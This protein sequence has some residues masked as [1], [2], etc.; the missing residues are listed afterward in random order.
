MTN[1]AG[2]YSVYGLDDTKDDYIIIA[3][4]RGYERQAITGQNPAT[5]GTTANFDLVPPMV[6]YT[7]SGTVKTDVPS[8]IE[9]AIVLVSSAVKN[10]FSTTRTS[11]TGLYSV[12]KLVASTDYKIDVIPP[13]LP[14]QSDTFTVSADN[15]VKDFTIHVGKNIGGVVT[16]SEAFPATKKVYVFLYKGSI[17]QGFNVAS[18]GGAF[19]FKGLSDGTDYKLLAVAAGYTPQWYNGKTTIGTADEIS[20]TDGSKDDANITLIKQ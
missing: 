9:G 4:R 14:M 15:V 17:Y 5:T 20:I 18:T 2:F 3:Q 11:A 16:G 1:S 6:Y 10:F 13:G 19:L 12:D 7:V 8:G